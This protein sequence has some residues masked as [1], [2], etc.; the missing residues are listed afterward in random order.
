MGQMEA[1]RNR[2]RDES[3]FQRSTS[4]L[5]PALHSADRAEFV[6]F[7]QQCPTRESAR[8][9]WR[10]T[11]RG[12]EIVSFQHQGLTD[13]LASWRHRPAITGTAD[14]TACRYNQILFGSITPLSALSLKLRNVRIS[15]HN[16]KANAFGNIKNNSRSDMDNIMAFTRRQ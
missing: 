6:A 3:H 16:S 15:P 10:T 8:L 9:S 11:S 2:F 7:Q 14:A 12:G 5:R 13:K 1:H 4:M